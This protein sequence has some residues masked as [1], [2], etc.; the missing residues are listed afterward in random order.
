MKKKSFR[1]LNKG[2]FIFTIEVEKTEYIQDVEGMSD[3]EKNNIPNY[4]TSHVVG[5]IVEKVVHAKSFNRNQGDRW[6]PNFVCMPC[7]RYEVTY[8]TSSSG[9]NTNT[10]VID[11]TN[12]DN[13]LYDNGTIYVNK[14]DA[15]AE[16]KKRYISRCEHIKKM[17]DW[18]NKEYEER[19]KSEIMNKEVVDTEYDRYEEPSEDMHD[20]VQ[21]IVNTSMHKQTVALFP[22]SFNPFTIGHKAIVEQALRL[23]DKVII[24]FGINPD[25]KF[26]REEHMR[27]ITNV[28]KAFKDEPRVS[29]REYE[30]L[31]MDYAKR[32]GAV[33]IRGLR[34]SKDFEYEQHIA[35]INKKVGDVDTVFIV[36]DPSLNCISSSMV[37]ELKKYGK[38]VTKFII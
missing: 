16:L 8:T 35:E 29:V 19:M 10:C 14:A 4:S 34:D 22:G 17:S 20:D 23:F 28:C 26:D 13:H 5:H 9:C 15:E 33:I 7:D 3:F 25:K 27:Q 6:Y 37:R 36:C 21:Q 1:E 38:D 2:D 24:G 31:T 11:L 12:S 32:L 30:G 18:Y